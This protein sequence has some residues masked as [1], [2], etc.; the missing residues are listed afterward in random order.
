MVDSAEIVKK[1]TKKETKRKLGFSFTVY[2]LYRFF[3]LILVA[4][5]FAFYVGWGL[6]YNDW[7]DIGVYSLVAPSVV[8]G[9]L[10]IALGFEKQ[11]LQ[12]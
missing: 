2:S 5:P 7:G 9:I 8:F 6:A 4:I 12:K 1:E 3:G 10:I 11:R